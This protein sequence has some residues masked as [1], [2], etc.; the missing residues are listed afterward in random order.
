MAQLNHFSLLCQSLTL[1]N[2]N[3]IAPQMMGEV[4]TSNT[5]EEVSP[6]TRGSSSS[7]TTQ[8]NLDELEETFL[9]QEVQEEVQ[10]LDKM[11]DSE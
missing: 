2:R 8:D 9:P 6:L 11:I 10:V 3:V 7:C 5:S 4:N 1:P